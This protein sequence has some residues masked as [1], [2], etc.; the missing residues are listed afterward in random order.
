MRLIPPEAASPSMTVES[1][2]D[3]DR[4]RQ[5]DMPD[6]E[7]RLA[8]VTCTSRSNYKLRGVLGDGGE[9]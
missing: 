8:T 7:S 2:A 1:T 6:I 3:R 5:R 4:R 9:L